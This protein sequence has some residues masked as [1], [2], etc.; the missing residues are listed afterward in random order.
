[1]VANTDRLV[2]DSTDRTG[3]GVLLKIASASQ[4]D[5]AVKSRA[6]LGMAKE[7]IGA[8]FAVIST[9]HDDDRDHQVEGNY[10]GGN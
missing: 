1:M 3:E 6:I 8:A 5:A 10:S 2:K 4:V 7:S 9:R